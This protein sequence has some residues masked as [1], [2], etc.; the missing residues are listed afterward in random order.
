MFIVLK[1]FKILLKLEEKHKQSYYCSF[2][3]A[4]SKDSKPFLRG[5]GQMA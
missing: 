2:P 1:C 4:V 3:E 5:T